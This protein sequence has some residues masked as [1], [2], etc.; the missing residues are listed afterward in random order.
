MTRSERFAA[1]AAAAA[2]VAWGWPALTSGY[3]GPYDEGNTLCAATRVLAGE[4]PYRDFWSLHPPGTTWLLAGAFR[5][6]GAT[7][8]VER[9]VKIGVVALA[10]VL[11]FLLARLAARTGW[12][13]ASALL[14]VVLPTQTLSLRSRDAGL[15]LVLATLL[16]ACAPTD[17]PRR[18]ALVAGLLA[19][20][21]FWFKQDFVGAAAVAGAIAVGTSAALSAPL[22]RKLRATLF[23]ALIP[24]A[25]GLSIGLA[26]LA[27]TLAVRG[28]FKEF[29]EQAIL[30]PTSSFGRFRSIPLSLRFEQVAEAFGR[31]ISSNVA[32]NAA[33][34]PILFVAVLVAALAGAA[35][36]GVAL[37]RG[38]GGTAASA[39]VLLAS[40]VAGFLLL[41]APWQRADLEH[42]NPALALA[43]VALAAL[44][45]P[46][47]GIAAP[48]LRAAGAA[49]FAA[50]ALI[51]L[52]ALAAPSAARGTAIPSDLAEAAR[53]VAAESKPGERIFVGNERHDRLVYN[54][55]LVYFLAGR[56]NATRYDNLH[57]GVIT[58]RTVQEEIVRSL[59]ASGARWI[60]LWEGPPPGEPNESSLS[61]GVVVLDEW[62]AR[63][64]REAARFG[65][66]RVMRIEEPATRR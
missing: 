21:T 53:F 19:G 57:P 55:P 36:G 13:A 17:R 56:P 47:E 64:A 2:A 11:L 35:C 12:A 1:C 52:V 18:R 20:L 29:F 10:A 5:V 41:A 33:A 45:G 24:F 30:F 4:T 28:T 60:V 62:I 34:V 61:S 14:F 48:R 7:L 27:A 43:L 39:S 25:V 54:A 40:S 59:E 37:R 8:G 51:A 42:L 38:A 23:D 44:A 31:G 65:S 58:T 15:V 46:R 32:L 3:E 49:L 6:F 50:V 22:G 63:R 9:A 16:A 66:T 26:T